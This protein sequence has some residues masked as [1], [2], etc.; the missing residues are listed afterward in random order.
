[1]NI[2]TIIAKNYV[3][4]ARVLAESFKQAHPDGNCTVLVIDDP[5][6]HINPAEEPFELLTID[7]IG[8]PDPMRMAAWYD[9][10]ELST[11]VKPWLLRTLLARPDYDH[12]VYLDPDIRIFAPLE[13]IE[14]RVAE[15]DVVLTPH[16]NKPLPRDGH[17]PAEE[18]ILIAGSYNLGFIALRAGQT[19]EELLD[20]WSER[21]E[22]H[23][24]NEPEV[25]RF[26][27]QR[28]IDLVP[29]IWPDIDVLRDPSYN[30]AY[31][32]LATRDLEEDGDGYRVDGRPLRF[33]H[34]SGFDP[35]RPKKLSKHQD[36]IKISEQP[37]LKR[38]C[39]EYAAQLIDHGYKQ[40][41]D[42]GYDWNKLP[43]GIRLDREAREIYREMI[44]AGGSGESVFTEQGAQRFA[45]Y[46]QA[47]GHGEV[48]RRPPP[49]PRRGANVVGYLSDPRGVGEAA[50]QLVAALEVAEI[51]TATVDAPPEQRKIP[52]RLGKL[53][54]D[55]YPYDFNLICVNA[56]TLPLMAKGLGPRFFERR[57]SAGL[58]FWEISHFPP[59]LRHAFDNVDEVW[60]ATQHVADSLRP[61]SP[62]TAASASART[63]RGW[64]R[65]SAKPSGRATGRLW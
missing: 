16:F 32:N 10:M 6:G 17:K 30:I 41:I 65:R 63:R 42:W 55:D 49:R 56:D 26:V 21:L 64:S 44:E 22:T 62:T 37:V 29:G 39:A 31:W 50:R 53:G 2:C 40:A 59:E 8:L 4:F 27:D 1:L 15:H 57:R 58:W 20:W 28:W 12:V 34:F 60:V 18:D 24:L 11:A 3:A 45:G 14:R 51:P 48:G 47:A 35:R 52:G 38:I 5:S 25:G 13:E 23:C 61:L 36:R 7:Q 54:F 33:F 43:N 46:L 9:V 19:A